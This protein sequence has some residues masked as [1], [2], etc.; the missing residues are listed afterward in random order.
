MKN[1]FPDYIVIEGPIG[2]GKTSLAKRLADT[3]NTELMLESPADNPFL[4]GFYEDPQA[5]ALQTQLFFL[6][7]R[8]KQIAMLR[9]TDMFKPVQVAD[10]FIEKDRLFASVTLNNAEFEL[11]QQVYDRITL[12]APIPNLVIYLQAPTDVLLKRILGRGIDYEKYIDEKY[13]QR[14]ANA[15]IDFFYHYNSAP[16]LIVNTADFDLV[17]GS[18]NYNLLLEYIKKL[19]PGRNYFNPKEL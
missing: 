17:N 14:I 8:A 18:R 10:F 7:Q 16:L 13:L 5:A 19:P 9:Q 12:E 3:F 11:Y 4:P 6:F 1:D 15:Y 2:V